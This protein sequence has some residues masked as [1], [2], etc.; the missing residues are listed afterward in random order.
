MQKILTPFLNEN[1]A[2]KTLVNNTEP[3]TLYLVLVLRNGGSNKKTLKNSV[4]SKLLFKKKHEAEFFSKIFS[5]ENVAQEPAQLSAETWRPYLLWVLRNLPHKFEKLADVTKSAKKKR[6]H[7]GISQ[8]S[9]PKNV[10][11]WASRKARAPKTSPY[12]HLAKLVPQTPARKHNKSLHQ[13]S[14]L[15]NDTDVTSDDYDH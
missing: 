6:H 1:V 14:L 10:T 8:S 3:W 7:M 11:I 9:C 12:G 15:L 13:Q 5:H 4:F 2:Y